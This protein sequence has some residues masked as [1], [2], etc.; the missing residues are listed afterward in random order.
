MKALACLHNYVHRG[1]DPRDMDGWIAGGDYEHRDIL[2]ARVS[3]LE[4]IEKGMEAPGK[5]DGLGF[6]EDME[7]L[8]YVELCKIRD[9]LAERLWQ[10]YQHYLSIVR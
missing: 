7:T 5:Y 6:R 4:A 10:A 8:T 3:F 2:E 9:P 1:A